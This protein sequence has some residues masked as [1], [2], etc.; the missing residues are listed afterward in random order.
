MAAYALS[1]GGLRV[2][3]L[4]KS[5]LPRYK[6]CGGGLLGRTLQWLPLDVRALVERECFAAELVHHS[7]ALHFTSKR[8]QSVV[9]M[10][11]RDRFDHHLTQ[12]AQALGAV[13]ISGEPVNHI[14]R[15]A[16]GLELCTTSTTISARFVIG[17][18]GVNSVVARKLGLPELPLV[19]PA[20]ESEVTVSAAEFE[21]FRRAARFDFGLTPYGYAWVFPKREHLSIGVLTTRRGSCNLNDEYLRYLAKLGL[22]GPRQEE[23]HGYMIPIRPRDKM[24][25]EPRVLL[26]GDAAGLVDPVTAEGISA[27]VLSGQLAAAAILENKFAPDATMRAYRSRLRATLLSELRIARVLAFFLYGFPRVRARILRRHGQGLSE[28]MT[29]LV[30]GSRRYGQAVSQPHHYLKLLR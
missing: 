10:V 30:M 8:T 11:M 13:L 24:F 27:A 17:A 25:S 4:E 18:D 23:R 7:P 2:V 6:T 5:H 3:I 1:K 22:E 28:F 14:A 26:V 12:A 15:N 20:I 16:N 19:I 21:R 29:D 9:S